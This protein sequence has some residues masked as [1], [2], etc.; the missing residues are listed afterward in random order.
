[1]I[2]LSAFHGNTVSAAGVDRAGV[3]STMVS[4]AELDD[5]MHRAWP[6]LSTCRID[7]WVA[8]FA[9]GVTQRA[10]SVLPIDCPTD[11][12]DAI[13]EVESLYRA[14]GLPP[15]FQIS[16]AAQP[17][18]LDTMLAGREYQLRTPTLVQV[19]RVDAAVRKPASPDTQLTVDEEPGEEWMR[20]WWRVDRRGGLEAREIA[21]RILSSCPALYARSSDDAGTTAVGRLAMLDRWGGIYCMAVREDVRRRGYARAILHTLLREAEE[22]R[23]QQ[24]WLQ[25]VADNLGARALYTQA[26]FVD[27]SSYHYRTKPIERTEM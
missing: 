3:H 21:R 16:P 12:T 14:R 1:M 18:V 15:T 13:D 11:L 5:L 7:G 8:R 6:G 25:V 19:A 23:I 24:V 4:P 26:G 10:N 9:A 17:G 27:A 22:R 2:V 20:L